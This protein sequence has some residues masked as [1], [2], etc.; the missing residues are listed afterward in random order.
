MNNKSTRSKNFPKYELSNKCA[1][2]YMYINKGAI[3]KIHDNK[4]TVQL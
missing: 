1:T 4:Y 3:S 2:G